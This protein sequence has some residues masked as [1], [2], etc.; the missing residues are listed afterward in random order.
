MACCESRRWKKII[1]FTVVLNVFLSVD[2]L[3]RISRFGSEQVEYE[4]IVLKIVPV[5][6]G[7]SCLQTISVGYAF[8]EYSSVFVGPS[9][10]NSSVNVDCI[11]IGNSSFG[12]SPVKISPVGKKIHCSFLN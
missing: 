11:I 8:I 5:P 7:I 9:V 4:V 2:L 3:V 12:Y 6:V 10:S 1:L